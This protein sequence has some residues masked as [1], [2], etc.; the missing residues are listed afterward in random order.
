MKIFYHGSTAKGLKVLKPKMDP[1]LG[2]K[3]VFVADEPYG[4]MMFSLLPNRS[5]STDYLI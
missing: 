5:K 4:P 3:G 2:I 1:R